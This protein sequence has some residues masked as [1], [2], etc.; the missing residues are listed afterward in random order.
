[1]W[2]LRF[3][4]KQ[5]DTTTPKFNKETHAMELNL[6]DLFKA[7]D[8]VLSAPQTNISTMRLV[9]LICCGLELLFERPNE[10]VVTGALGQP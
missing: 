9:L 1:M 6:D 8:E 4:V 2:G 3:A 10:D 7:F 5:R